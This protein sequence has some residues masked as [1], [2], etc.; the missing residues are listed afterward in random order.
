MAHLSGVVMDTAERMIRD[1]T[2]ESISF[3]R[4]LARTDGY[5][6]TI[7]LPG[8][9]AYSK[10]HPSLT[11]ALYDAVNYLKNGEPPVTILPG[12]D[13]MTT[14]PGLPGLVTR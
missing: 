5:Y 14:L 2:I 10:Q 9:N 8:Q 11:L 3:G 7:R 13:D 6:V 1:G 12:L 4:C